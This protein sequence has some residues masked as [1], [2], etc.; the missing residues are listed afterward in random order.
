[1]CSY[2]NGHVRGFEGNLKIHKFRI[3]GG[4]QSSDA[5]QIIRSFL[6]NPAVR[7]ILE[8]LVYSLLFHLVDCSQSNSEDNQS[9]E[10]SLIELKSSV[11]SMEFFDRLS[12]HG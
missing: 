7:D 11:R 10:T 1:M 8:V 6:A 3:E 2:M 5:E 9:S 12:E 4:V